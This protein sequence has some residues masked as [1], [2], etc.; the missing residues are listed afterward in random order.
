MI[1][2]TA[3]HTIKEMDG[4]NIPFRASV[5]DAINIAIFRFLLAAFLCR[6]VSPPPNAVC[7]SRR[8]G[9]FRSRLSI[10]NYPNR[11]QSVEG[12]MYL[13]KEEVSTVFKGSL[14]K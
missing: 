10:V 3:A 8:I 13:T 2:Q 5:P 7:H 12:F 6:N 11:H 1:P 4:L 14:V 9:N